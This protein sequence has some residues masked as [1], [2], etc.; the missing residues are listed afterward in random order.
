[1]ADGVKERLTKKLA[2]LGVDFSVAGLCGMP[3]DYQ[4]FINERHAEFQEQAE[5]AARE[6]ARTYCAEHYVEIQYFLM[7]GAKAAFPVLDGFKQPPETCVQFGQ[8]SDG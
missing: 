7:R 5:Y 8:D 4:R 2:V 3:A 6:R 1:M